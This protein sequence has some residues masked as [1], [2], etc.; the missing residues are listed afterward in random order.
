MA[1]TAGLA[2]SV[3]DARADTPSA[4]GWW[5][6][7]NPGALTDSGLT[8]SGAP[9]DIPEGGLE[10]ANHTSGVVSYAAIASSAHGSTQVVLN[11]APEAAHLPGSKVQACPLTGDGVFASEYGAPLSQG[12]AYDCSTFVAGEQDAAAGTVTFE[13][14]RFVNDGFLA[15]AIIGVGTTRLVFNPPNETTIQTT[16]APSA[17]QPPTTQPAPA[18]ERRI[19]APVTVQ[20]AFATPVLT[21]SSPQVSTEPQMASAAPPR[22][23]RL[24]AI[25]EPSNTTRAG[26][27][28]TGALVLLVAAFGVI[29]RN[30]RALRQSD[31]EADPQS[32]DFEM[33]HPGSRAARFRW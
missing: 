18:S 1:V 7:E 3:G 11:L 23:A 5:T 6:A 33:S 16:P 24:L 31:T 12:P 32:A 8:G 21:V 22:V 13:A 20:P 29:S 4:V 14:G 19:P 17:S 25:S 30:R 26:S 2:T 28:V 10:V 15:V 27:A 9:S